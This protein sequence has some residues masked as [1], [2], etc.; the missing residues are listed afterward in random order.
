MTQTTKRIVRLYVRFLNAAD[1]IEQAWA[2]SYEQD[3]QFDGGEFSG[4]AIERAKQRDL[5]RR[6]QRLGFAD[7]DLLYRV[8]A[9][10]VARVPYPAHVYYP[11]TAPIPN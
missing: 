4:P 5:D 10:L 3:S 6:A 1:A 9:L 8:G 7:A 11:G 2:E